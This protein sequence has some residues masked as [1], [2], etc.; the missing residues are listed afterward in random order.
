MDCDAAEGV[1]LGGVVL[2]E[3]SGS[4]ISIFF[5]SSSG[6]FASFRFFEPFVV[7]VIIS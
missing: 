7:T 6:F 3:G 1:E 2:F 5:L 4:L